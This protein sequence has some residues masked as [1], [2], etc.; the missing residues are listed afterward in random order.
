MATPLETEYRRRVESWVEHG[1]GIV[2]SADALY[3]LLHDTP[4]EAPRR[5][6][7][8]VWADTVVAQS[9]VP[10]INRLGEEDLIPRGWVKKTDY[11]F[12]N[13][14]IVKV[15]ITGLDPETGLI[16]TKFATLTYDNMPTLGLI[17]ED[18]A[19]LV[20][21]DSPKLTTEFYLLEVMSVSHMR[22]KPW[23]TR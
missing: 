13:P 15:G 8:E 11:K 4:F 3:A 2:T 17:G 18:S 6:V 21:G 23:S 19:A 12:D 16:K 5:V 22:G 10:L 7:R 14:F 20:E 1:I 9:Y